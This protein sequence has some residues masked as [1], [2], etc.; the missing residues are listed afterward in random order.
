MAISVRKHISIYSWCNE[1]ARGQ[2]VSEVQKISHIAVCKFS[3][4]YV[5]LFQCRIKT[6]ANRKLITSTISPLEFTWIV[7]ENAKWNFEVIRNEK[8]K[9]IRKPIFEVTNMSAGIERECKH[10]SMPCSKVTIK[11]VELQ[12][13]AQSRAYLHLLCEMYARI[14]NIKVVVV[15]FAGKHLIAKPQ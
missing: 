13:K 1:K 9:Q 10:L 12:I 8:L 5:K 11:C 2:V 4:V 7:L 6:T 14:R 3:K 15:G